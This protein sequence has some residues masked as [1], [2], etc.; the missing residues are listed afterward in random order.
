MSFV[1]GRRSQAGSGGTGAGSS[2]PDRQSVPGK[3]TLTEGLVVQRKATGSSESAP[4]PGAAVAAAATSTGM[5]ADPAMR[6]RVEQVTG[7]DLGG[8]RVHTGAPSHVAAQ[9]LS[10]RA[11]TVGQNVHFASGE[12]RPG[13]AD[14][15]RLLAHELAHTVQQGATASAPQ[16]KLEVSQP[17]DA[18]EVEADAVATA[19]T[20][21]GGPVAVTQRRGVMLQREAI[22]GNKFGSWDFTQVNTN[23]ANS[24]AI[25]ASEVNIAFKPDAA[26]VDST[27]IAFVQNVQI[28]DSG[29]KSFD[30]RDNFKNRMTDD[31]STID[32]VADRKFGYYGYNNDGSTAGNAKAGTT[33]TK[34]PTPATMYD[35]PSFNKPDAKWNFEAAV[36][37]KAGADAGTIYGALQWGFD[38]DKDNKLTSHKAQHL[39]K[40]T[41]GFDKAVAKW[42]DQAKGDDSK[43]NR[44]DQVE[45]GPFK[46]K[47]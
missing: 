17:G 42:N 33:A 45:L 7:A 10:A 37:A 21:A 8:V 20:G 3:R 31:G 13:S 35:K 22:A 2:G 27:E 43:R 6:A 38:V 32:R 23:G 15:N 41:A 34:P 29:N 47:K 26:T 11:F 28:L 9:S 25:Y 39:D 30:N 4:D 1:P 44:K 24:S 16:C 19:A 46:S 14:G 18:A 12:Y 40:Q 5:A 36:T